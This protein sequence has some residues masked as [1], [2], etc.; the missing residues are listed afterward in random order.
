MVEAIDTLRWRD[1]DCPAEYAGLLRYSMP[2]PV[3]GFGRGPATGRGRG[4]GDVGD[5]VPLAGLLGVELDDS[6]VGPRP[7][8]DDA[9]GAREDDPAG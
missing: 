5:R 4:E 2:V 6:G 8:T 3:R 1:S 7:W 9:A